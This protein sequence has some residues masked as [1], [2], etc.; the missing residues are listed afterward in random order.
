VCKNEK[1][2]DER[3][4]PRFLNALHRLKSIVQMSSSLPNFVPKL[5][6]QLI[7]FTIPTTTKESFTK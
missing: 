6:S 1:P 3:N 7:F 5:A 4:L 2:K